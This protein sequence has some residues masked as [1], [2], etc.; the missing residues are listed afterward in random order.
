MAWTT[1]ILYSQNC[2]EEVLA[3]K[4]KRRIEESPCLKENKTWLSSPLSRHRTREEGRQT[5]WPP[6]S[7]L[8]QRKAGEFLFFLFRRRRRLREWKK[9]TRTGI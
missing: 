1:A 6:P 4:K 7:S 8:Q 5:G 2:I 9:T 3:V